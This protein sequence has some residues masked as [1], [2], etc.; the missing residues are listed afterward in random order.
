MMRSLNQNKKQLITLLFLC[1][2]MHPAAAKKKLKIRSCTMPNGDV[3]L[4]DKPCPINSK[5]DDYKKP[6]KPN[7]KSAKLPRAKKKKSQPPSIQWL[8]PESQPAAKTSHHNP[9]RTISL[10]TLM[11]SIQAPSQWFIQSFKVQGGDA[12]TASAKRL[13][14]PGKLVTGASLKRFNNTSRYFNKGAFTVAIDMFQQI[15]FNPQHEL[16]ESEFVAHPRFKVF[17]VHYR[18]TRLRQ[19]TLKAVTQFYVDDENNDLYVLHFQAPENHWQRLS[20]WQQQLFSEV[21]L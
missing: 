16:T 5:T 8:N 20:K 6:T 3:V 7:K 18:K 17:N 9:E 1:L 11:A 15:R 19:S 14:T 21:A 12:I 13:L 10:R 2:M 4:M